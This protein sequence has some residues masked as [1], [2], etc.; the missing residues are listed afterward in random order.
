[1]NEEYKRR[2]TG[3]TLLSYIRL[4]FFFFEFNGL[5]TSF[6]DAKSHLSSWKIMRRCS[7]A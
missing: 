6:H 5:R 3:A 1:M 4:N 7:M 2:P